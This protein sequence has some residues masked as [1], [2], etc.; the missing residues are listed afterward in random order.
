VRR[1]KEN[2]PSHL[3]PY[4]RA[5]CDSISFA[6]LSGIC[7]FKRRIGQVARYL[8]MNFTVTSIFYLLVGCGV[9][10]AILLKDSRRVGFGNIGQALAAVFFWPFFIPLLLE[11][12][13]TTIE[14]IGWNNS[15]TSNDALAQAIAQVET[16]L[17]GALSSLDGWSDAVLVPEQG[18]FDEL[19]SAWRSQAERIREL[20]RLLSDPAFQDISDESK[21]DEHL[22]RSE[23][24]R[25]DNIARLKT[26][27]EQLRSDLFGTIAWVRELVTMIHLARYTG[28]PATRAEE[29]VRQIATAVEGLSEVSAWRDAEVGAPVS[30]SEVQLAT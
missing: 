29:L 18:R 14:P 27:R 15:Y 13:A 21:R 11:S 2:L 7:S 22:S 4:L 26:I 19:R 12:T 20:D 30:C 10:V 5:L 8:I 17:N 28:A 24:A 3:V 23:H 1:E 25:R 16:E 6:K 9:A